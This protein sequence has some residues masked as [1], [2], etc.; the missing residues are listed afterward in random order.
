MRVWLENILIMPIEVTLH[1]NPRS[2]RTVHLAYLPTSS[3]NVRTR[4]HTVRFF[5]VTLNEMIHPIRAR[6]MIGNGQGNIWSEYEQIPASP[7]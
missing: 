2:A 4:T 3:R 5:E 6:Q 7:F 1:T